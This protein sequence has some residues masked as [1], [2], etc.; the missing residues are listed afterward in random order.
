MKFGRQAIGISKSADNKALYCAAT[1]LSLPC[2][3]INI[4]FY[5][6]KLKINNQGVEGEVN[7]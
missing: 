2:V 7:R 3:A 4:I 1:Y 5:V 6:L